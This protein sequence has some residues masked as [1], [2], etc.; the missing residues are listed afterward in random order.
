MNRISIDNGLTIHA[1]FQ[2]AVK[3]RRQKDQLALA[4]QARKEKQDARIWLMEERGCRLEKWRERLHTKSMEL[5]YFSPDF[6]RRRRDRKL[7]YE[8]FL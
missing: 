6:V 7:S 1:M 4:R 8:I 5:F 2:R 3:K